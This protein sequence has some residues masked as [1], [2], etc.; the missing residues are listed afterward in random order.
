MKTWITISLTF[1]ALASPSRAV[2][3]T[4]SSHGAQTQIQQAI[5]RLQMAVIKQDQAA[6]GELFLPTNDEWTAL[7]YSINLDTAQGK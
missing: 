4:N 3:A 6:L 7:V 5:E 1:T 2:A